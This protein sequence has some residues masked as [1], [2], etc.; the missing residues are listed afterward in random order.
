MWASAAFQVADGG[1]GYPA[2]PLQ[3]FL[4][5]S[6]VQRPLGDTNQ[7]ALFAAACSALRLL[8][9]R[10]QHAPEEMLDPRERK[11]L[12]QLRQAV[13]AASW[14]TRLWSAISWISGSA[15]SQSRLRQGRGCW[16]ILSC[17]GRILPRHS[18]GPMQYASPDRGA[19]HLPHN[20]RWSGPT[21]AA[22]VS[23]LAGG[24]ELRWFMNFSSLY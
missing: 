14:P 15:P 4:G 5:V 2:Q 7:E 20:T 9:D 17:C 1:A 13:R 3:L 21:S 16:T 6:P 12:K 22:I 8:Q 19:V 18:P 24:N 23:L 11:V 10:Q